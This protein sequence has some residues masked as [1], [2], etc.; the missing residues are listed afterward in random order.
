LIMIHPWLPP[1]AHNTDL[2]SVMLTLWNTKIKQGVRVLGFQA[3][4]RG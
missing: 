4:V 1:P 3:A 2:K